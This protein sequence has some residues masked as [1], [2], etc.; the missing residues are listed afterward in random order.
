MI[1][2]KLKHGDE[3]RIISPSANLDSISADV[4]KKAENKLKSFG[5]NVSY[6]KY[7]KSNNKNRT[8]NIKEKLHD[9]HE[10]FAD[11]KVKAIFASR[12]GYN[13][14]E[15]LNKIDYQL[16]KNNPKIFCGFSDITALCNAIHAKTNLTTYYAPN[17]SSLG[18]IKGSEYITKYLFKCLMNHEKYEIRPSE[19]WSEDHWFFDQYNRHY[20]KNKGYSIINEGK[21]EGKIIGGH[22]STLSLLFGTEYLSIPEN[23]ILIIE[24]NETSLINLERLFKSLHYQKEFKNVIGILFGR[25]ESNNNIL[26]E[27]IK[28]LIKRNIEPLNIPIIA[29]VDFGHTMPMATF[30]IGGKIKIFADTKKIELIIKNF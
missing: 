12:G 8:L 11:K 7:Y 13:S 16:I 20:I 29:G 9:L 10:A 28:E 2:P 26:I 18:M 30:P 23:T 19:L 1:P 14:I 15:L 22:L 25:F 6:S 5:F 3:I 21:A 24:D 4:L 17:F 27:N